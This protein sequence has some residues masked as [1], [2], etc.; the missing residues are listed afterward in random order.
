MPVIS[1]PNNP[2]VGDEYTYGTYTWAWSGLA[3][4]AVATTAV[5][6][7]P[8]TPDTDSDWDT[9]PSTIGEALNELAARLRNLE[10]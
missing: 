10:G 8:F 7:S 4:K 2:E 3:W 6:A 1:F 5:D 9:A